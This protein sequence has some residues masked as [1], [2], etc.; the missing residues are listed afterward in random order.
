MPIENPAST[1]DESNDL[2]SA[3]EAAWDEASQEPAAQEAAA[4]DNAQVPEL[5]DKPE[6]VRDEQGRFTKAEQDAADAKALDAKPA[7][8]AKPAEP[9]APTQPE[10]E[11]Q[12]TATA[13]APPPGWSIAAKAEFDKLPPAVREAVAK[14]ETEI[15]QGFAKLTEYKGLDPY[16]EMAKRS[17]TTITQALEGYTRAEQVLAT[18]FVNGVRDLCRYYN[19]NPAQLAQEL[20]LATPG[21]QPPAQ[22]DPISPVFQKVSALEQR[23][24]QY[25]QQREMEEQQAVNGTLQQFASDPANRY[26]ENVKMDMGRFIQAGMATDLKDAYDKACWAN[27]EIRALQIREAQQPA[28]QQRAQ[29]VSQ[30][31]QASKSIPTGAPIPGVQQGNAAPKSIR[32]ALDEAWNSLAST[33]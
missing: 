29:A 24:A 22:N 19:F 14:R 5:D 6:R 25:E 20:G 32:G 12:K 7:V 3:I 21:N 11:E 27:P 18:D 16:V 10:A 23:L 8:E 31:R 28:I 4:I 1:P 26:F 2:R 33:I 30:A 9:Q 15:N 17:G 13:T